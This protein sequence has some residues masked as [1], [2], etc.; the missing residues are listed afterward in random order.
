MKINIKLILTHEDIENLL[1]YGPHKY[2]FKA[3]ENNINSDINIIIDKADPNITDLPLNNA[4]QLTT[5][6]APS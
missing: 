3:K 4:M 2:L 6:P 5:E 1:D